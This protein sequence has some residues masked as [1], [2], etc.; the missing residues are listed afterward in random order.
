[1]SDHA[2]DAFTYSNAPYRG[3]DAAT[4]DQLRD[5]LHFWERTRLVADRT[6]VIVK[7]YPNVVAA[8]GYYMTVKHPAFPA[9]AAYL[10]DPDA[11][12]LRMKLAAM[13]LTNVTVHKPGT[14]Q[15]DVSS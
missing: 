7:V 3:S 8:R 2:A 6:S 14:R 4:L 10:R 12:V 5:T 9:F 1:M 13:G 15:W 11:A